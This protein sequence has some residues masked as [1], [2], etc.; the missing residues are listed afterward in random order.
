MTT[1]T[2]IEL[3]QVKLQVKLQKKLD[4][5][6]TDFL[7][8]YAVWDV[9]ATMKMYCM[10]YGAMPAVKMTPRHLDRKLVER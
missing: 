4:R 7:V 2:D 3:L 6:N 5:N 9:K 8:E 10:I 1:H